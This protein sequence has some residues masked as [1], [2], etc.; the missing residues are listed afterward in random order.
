[1]KPS[2]PPSSSSGHPSE[3]KGRP[4]RERP[5]QRP[6]DESISREQVERQNDHNTSADGLR[7]ERSSRRS[8]GGIDIAEPRGR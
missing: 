6:A 5:I 2:Q 8:G 1:M 7:G 3:A 4:A